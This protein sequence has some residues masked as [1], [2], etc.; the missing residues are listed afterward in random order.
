MIT[1]A[2]QAVQP[3]L[4]GTPDELVE[5]IHEYSDRGVTHFLLNFPDIHETKSVTLFAER[6]IQAL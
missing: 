3:R 5:Q 4:M 1:R 2:R 6:V